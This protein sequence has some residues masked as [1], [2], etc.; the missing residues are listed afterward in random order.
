MGSV[1][2]GR[3]DEGFKLDESAIQNIIENPQS[4][5]KLVRNEQKTFTFQQTYDF[6]KLLDGGGLP[7]SDFR[8]NIKIMI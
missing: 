7:D 1:K 8:Q 2:N 5:N 4:D 3:L 6:M